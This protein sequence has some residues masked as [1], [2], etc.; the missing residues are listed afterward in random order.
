MHKKSDVNGGSM[1]NDIGS[2]T[3]D[4]V[5]HCEKMLRNV[6]LVHFNIIS[7]EA[8]K[9]SRQLNIL[10]QP[11]GQVLQATIVGISVPT[12]GCWAL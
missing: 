2:I 10:S 11:H 4:H 8:L 6:S 7:F 12:N 9:N 3:I 1:W 5:N